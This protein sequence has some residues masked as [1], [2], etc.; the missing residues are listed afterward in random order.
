[1]SKLK[2]EYDNSKYI[3]NIGSL[4]YNLTILFDEIHN[5]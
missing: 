3:A 1:M 2:Y 4:F 5:I